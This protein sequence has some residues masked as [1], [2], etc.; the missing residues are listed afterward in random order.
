MQVKVFKTKWVYASP[1]LDTTKNDLIHYSVKQAA[2]LS[3]DNKV[4]SSPKKEMVV[5][6][7]FF[8]HI[9]FTV[10]DMTILKLRTSLMGRIVGLFKE[11]NSGISVWCY[12]SIMF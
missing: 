2:E 8:F 5:F 12:I 10:W 1:Y 4:V 9:L 7:H 6:V 3:E 11:K